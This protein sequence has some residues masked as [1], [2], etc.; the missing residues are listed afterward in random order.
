[1]FLKGRKEIGGANNTSY[2]QWKG[3]QGVDN[4]GLKPAKTKKAEPR[5][6]AFYFLKSF[7][8]SEDVY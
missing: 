4:Y 2:L 3:K 5:D 6:P 7:I 1:M 8:V